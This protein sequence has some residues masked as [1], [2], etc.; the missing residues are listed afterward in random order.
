[1]AF[2]FLD[3]ILFAGV[4]QGIF[5]IL[6]LQFISRK[7]KK[8]NK[9]LKIIIGLA[10]FMFAGKLAVFQ[11]N[12]RLVWRAALL[13]D[14]SIYLFGP[15]IYMY[16]RAFVYKQYSKN[17]LSYKHY[18]PSFMLFLFFCWALT[19]TTEEYV[20]NSYSTEMFITYFAMEATGI[21]SLIVYSYLCYTIL[22]DFQATEKPK[23]TTQKSSIRF[24]KFILIGLLLMIIFWSSGVFKTYILHTATSYIS[25]NLLWIV[26]TS[27]LFIVGYF[28]FTQP[29]IVR[30]PMEKKKAGKSRLNTTEI[31][32]ISKKLTYFIEE[33]KIYMQ[34]DLNLKMLAKKLQTSSNNISWLLNSVHEKT[35]YEYINEYRIKAFLQKIE[36]GEHKKQ[37]LLAIATDA[38][39]NSKSTFNKTF[40]SLMNDTPSNYIEKMY[41]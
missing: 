11:L 33:E 41:S 6:S 19:L 1:M 3:L 35:F 21:V 7:N 28:S 13:A 10:T 25:Y 23:S 24:L 30:I 20:A 12:Y 9:I 15:L 5:L 38:G 29:E 36:D 39:F 16:F 2:S 27:F 26:M 4:T 14:C 18:I 40:K 8:A 34:S 31:E 37:T 17:I 32:D 22:K